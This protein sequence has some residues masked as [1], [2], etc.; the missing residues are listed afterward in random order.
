MLVEPI[1]LSLSLIDLTL[2][3]GVA[4]VLP[5]ALGGHW[6]W[7]GMAAGSVA[8]ACSRDQGAVAVLI[9]LPWAA[10]GVGA[11]VQATRAAGPLLFWTRDDVVRVLAGGYGLVAA[12]WLLLSRGGASPMGIREPI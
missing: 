11:V 8:I 4:V 1:L 10:V 7:W 3:G 5:A 12:S 2:V 9:G 6:R